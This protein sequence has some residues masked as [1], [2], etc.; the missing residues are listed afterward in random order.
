[1]NESKP[2]SK[3]AKLKIENC[4][5]KLSLLQIQHQ[6]IGIE[7]MQII[8]AEFK[9]L[10]CKA[11]EWNFDERNGVLIKKPEIKKPENKE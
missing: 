9:R 7:K 3:I 5:L 6:Q 8:D 1:M 10:K 4:N 2:I 11:N